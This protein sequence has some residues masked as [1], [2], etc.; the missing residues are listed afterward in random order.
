MTRC[1]TLLLLALLPVLA[2]GESRP[3][4]VSV[5][6]TTSSVPA[7]LTLLNEQLG[8]R[9][10]VKV[11]SDYSASIAANNE[12]SDSVDVHYRGAVRTAR[13]QISKSE[14]GEITFS[15]ST[16]GKELAAAIC[17]QMEWYARTTIS[18][19]ALTDCKTAF[20]EHVKT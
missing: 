20:L 4:A 2:S 6:L 19:R 13:Y 15:L 1:M 11:L 10:P 8:L 17:E 14:V 5:A 16:F 3:Y 7:Y 18:A 12:Y 9:L